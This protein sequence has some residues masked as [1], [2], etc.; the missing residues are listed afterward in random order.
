MSG[1]GGRAVGP[2]QLLHGEDVA[3]AASDRIPCVRYRTRTT[4]AVATSAPTIS[5]AK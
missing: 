2:A 5:L 4:R 1:A 3:A